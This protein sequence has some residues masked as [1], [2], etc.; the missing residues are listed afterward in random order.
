MGT[1]ENRARYDR[2]KLRYPS[3]LSDVEWALIEA[4]DPAG[5]AR[6]RQTHGDVREVVKTYCLM[7]LG[8]FDWLPM[9]GDPQGPAAALYRSMA[10][11]TCGPGMV[12]SIAFIMRSM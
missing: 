9:A 1:N 7:L 11:S 4:F 3:D 8:A 6:R 5:Q 2:S 10:I 12:R